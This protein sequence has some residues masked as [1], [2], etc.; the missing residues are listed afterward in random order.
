MTREAISRVLVNQVTSLGRQ[1]A[2]PGAEP[3]RTLALDIPVLWQ[4]QNENIQL[5]IQR[6]TDDDGTGAEIER[7]RWQVR[8]EFAMADMPPLGV[9]LTLE[10]GRISVLWRGEQGARQLLEPHL[11][12]LHERLQSLGLEV[13]AL[14]VRDAPFEK[15]AAE[16]AA[17]YR[18]LINIK[19]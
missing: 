14:G 12:S 2:E 6:E 10:A 1:A 5:R 3:G 4:G 9:V 17:P 13:G 11:E 15:T 19:T 8:L 18:P 7:A 16:P